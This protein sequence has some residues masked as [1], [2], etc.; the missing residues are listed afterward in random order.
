MTAFPLL[1]KL[2][3]KSF[4]CCGLMSPRLCVCEIKLRYRNNIRMYPVL[5]TIQSCLEDTTSGYRHL[6]N[7]ETD[8]EFLLPK[9]VVGSS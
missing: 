8:Y 5:L 7:G 6:P 4:R 3:F 2:T 9:R 1:A